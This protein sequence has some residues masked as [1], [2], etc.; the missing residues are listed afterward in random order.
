[1]WNT[2]EWWRVLEPGLRKCRVTSTSKPPYP[3][4][5]GQS[6]VFRVRVSGSVEL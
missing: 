4:F 6:S 2:S 1:M 3:S 5:G